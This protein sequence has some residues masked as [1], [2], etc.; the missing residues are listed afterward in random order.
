[1]KKIMISLMLLVSIVMLFC[2]CGERPHEGVEYEWI[3]TGSLELSYADQFSVD[4]YP[5]GY[6]IISISDGSR[7]LVIPPG[8][9]RPSG[10]SLDVVSLYQPVD[11]IYL[12]A[13]QSMCLFDALDALDNI[14]LSATKTDGWYVENARKAMEEGKILFA[15]KYSEPDYEMLLK[16]K[17]PLAIENNM[18]GHA[19]EVKDKLKELGIAVLVDQSSL[20]SH[21]LGRTEWIKLYGILAGKEK[22]AEAVFSEQVAHMEEVSGKE[23]TGK[24][25]AFF[26]INSA[27]QVV[28]RKSTDYVTKMIEIA[29][30]TYVF[31]DLGDPALHTS[32]V[33]LDM[34]EF[35]AAA[36]DADVIIY[37]STIGG[38]IQTISEL[39]GKNELMK[40]FKAVKNGNVWCTGK[41]MYQESTGIGVMIQSFHTIFSDDS[42]KLTEVPYLKKLR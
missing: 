3:K 23:K 36:K 13:S 42:G 29:G 41:N 15:G 33:N 27:G 21:P 22:E 26:Y 18:I 35:F 34:E 30:G 11:H 24:T 19:S 31:A 7:Y 37:N 6:K 25:V 32:T 1:M 38:E 40:E 5:N 2:S 10:L 8:Q 9:E 4:Y 20:E 17:C 16:H 14:E 39:V 12:A 28:A